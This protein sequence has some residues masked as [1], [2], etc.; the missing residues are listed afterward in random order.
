MSL[1]LNKK[2]LKN[3]MQKY[4]IYI[5]RHDGLGLSLDGCWGS[6]HARFN[7]LKAAEEAAEW[8]ETVYPNAEFVVRD[9]E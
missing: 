1:L 3:N 9:E 5:N 8:L 4:Q 6:E 2:E 7:D